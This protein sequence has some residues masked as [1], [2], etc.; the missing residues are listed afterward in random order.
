MHVA[1]SPGTRSNGPLLRSGPQPGSDNPRHLECAKIDT[2]DVLRR[3]DPQ[4]WSRNTL[5]LLHFM[6]SERRDESWHGSCSLP[7]KAITQT[8]AQTRAGTRKVETVMTPTTPSLR[9]RRQNGSHTVGVT[10]LELV[11]AVADSAETDQEVVATVVYMLRSGRVKLVGCL[12]DESISSL[13]S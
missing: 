7:G 4:A 9:S 12:R 8:G 5:D 3:L 6:Q 10:L 1:T 11:Q 2:R 13:A